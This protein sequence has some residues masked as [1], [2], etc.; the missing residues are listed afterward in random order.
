MNEHL[1]GRLLTATA[2][3]DFT[4]A[5]SARITLVSKATGTRFTYRV[6]RCADDEV[7]YF[8]ALLRGPENDTDYSYLG[9]LRAGA[10]R[11]GYRSK[12]GADAPSARAFAWFWQRVQDNR[13][14]D[15]LEVWHE[16]YCG[17]CGRSLTVPESVA[18][19]LGPDCAGIVYVGKT[20]LLL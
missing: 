20:S 11:H 19:G 12:I 14:P 15:S 3:A 7:L 5:G 6:R 9:T 16:G 4:L 13:L 8:V 2:A 10:Y 18:R 17:R 1:R